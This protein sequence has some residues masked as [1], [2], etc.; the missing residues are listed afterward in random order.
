VSLDQ[1]SALSVVHAEDGMPIFP[2]VVYVARGQQH[3][4]IVGSRHAPKIQ[5]SQEPQAL[6]FKPSADE[7]L[8][9]TAQVYGRATLAVVLSGIGRDG[10]EGARAVRA[11][12]G[13]ILTQAAE[14]CAVYGMPK[15]CVELG[16]S[17][18]ALEPVGIRQVIHQLSPSYAGQ[19]KR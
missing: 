17:D 19:D 13:M 6:L 1:M 10:S 18:A 8:R 5:I 9:S 4:R 7:L 16:L 15:T 3:M 14:T 11:A 12:G 2:G